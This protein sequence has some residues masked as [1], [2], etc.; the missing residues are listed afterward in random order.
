MIFYPCRAAHETLVLGGTHES[1]PCCVRSRG[2]R[3][4]CASRR[5][6]AS[7]NTY[8]APPHARANTARRPAAVTSHATLVLVCPRSGVHTCN[9]HAHA[10]ISRHH[11]CPRRSV[12]AASAAARRHVNEQ[13]ETN[14]TE[15]PN[16]PKRTSYVR[17]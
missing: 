2:R 8:D 7:P 1:P 4:V 13:N 3:D 17:D 10:C 15:K 9:S 12:S 14:G 11:T 5:K 16:S 6:R